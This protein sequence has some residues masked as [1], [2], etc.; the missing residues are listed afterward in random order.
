M[1]IIAIMRTRNVERP[2]FIV[3]AETD[4]L[5]AIARIKGEY[6]PDKVFYGASNKTA[7]LI[8]SNAG[9]LFVVRRGE[10]TE[11]ELKD[12]EDVTVL[13]FPRD[14][15]KTEEDLEDEAEFGPVEYNFIT[16]VIL[17][18]SYRPEG[19][20]SFRL[21]DTVKYSD[22]VYSYDEKQK[23][24]RDAVEK[25]ELISLSIAE[26]CKKAGMRVVIND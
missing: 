7:F 18:I 2:E 24:A 4:S 19:Y 12:I 8:C 13:Q 16:R 23:F 5:T 10:V 9:K 17:A 26:A 20:M 14:A 15:V 6:N 3:E 22:N 25:A 1:L 11:I 21:Y